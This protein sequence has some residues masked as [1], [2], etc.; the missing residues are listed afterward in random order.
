MKINETTS[1]HQSLIVP[2]F[3]YA[4]YFDELLKQKLSIQHKL[5]ENSEKKLNVIDNK[6]IKQENN[7]LISNIDDHDF[8]YIK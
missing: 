5:K 1:Y 8:K 2:D 3:K 4:R 6:I 7:E